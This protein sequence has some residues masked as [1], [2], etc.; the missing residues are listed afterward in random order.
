MSNTYTKDY[1]SILGVS[2]TAT[3]A[4]IKKA[5]SN[6]I[7]AFHPDYYNG[8]KDF[9]TKKS[10]EINEAYS[11][12]K[13]SEKRK[14]YDEYWNS[15][16]GNKRQNYY[17]S[18]NDGEE[19]YSDN[20][21]K[22]PDCGKI[23]SKS[24]KNCPNCGAINELY[25]YRQKVNRKIEDKRKELVAEKDKLLDEIYISVV[26]LV[27]YIAIL[28]LGFFVWH[29]KVGFVFFALFGIYGVIGVINSLMHNGDFSGLWLIAVA[30]VIFGMTDYIDN[31]IIDDIIDIGLLIYPVYYAVVRPVIKYKK[32]KKLCD[33]EPVFDDDGN[34]MNEI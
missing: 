2:N 14:E 6:L 29:W 12:L 28:L 9:A 19:S 30:V 20:L 15:I 8:D 1:Y 18:S 25:I 7:K 10:A 13:D 31:D 26:V 32:Y 11:V 33:F 17:S 5:Y 3:G 21:R 4:E 23:Y 22:C 24:A 16:H 34:I 27:L